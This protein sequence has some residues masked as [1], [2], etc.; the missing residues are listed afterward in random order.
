LLVITAQQEKNLGLEG[1]P[2]PIPIELSQERVLFEN[3][4]HEL[5]TEG[6]LEHLSQGGFSYA[7]YALNSNIH[8]SGIPLA[9]VSFPL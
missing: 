8:K 7:D 2:L 4:K 1:V 5:G 9:F 3:F 6:G